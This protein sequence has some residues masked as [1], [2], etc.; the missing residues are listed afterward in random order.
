MD[1]ELI[2]SG[3]IGL[4]ACGVSAVIYGIIVHVAFPVLTL[5]QSIVICYAFVVFVNSLGSK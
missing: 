1:K 5:L 4:A 2:L 3:L